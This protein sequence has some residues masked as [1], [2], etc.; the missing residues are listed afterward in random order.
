MMCACVLASLD[1]HGLY[2]C[3]CVAEYV[4]TMVV[5]LTGSVF[6]AV[7]VGNVLGF[8]AS[9]AS[10]NKVREERLN[11]VQALLLQF[12]VPKH[13]RQELRKWAV[14]RTRTVQTSLQ[15]TWTRTSERHAP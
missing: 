15:A 13:L 4:F 6:V 9:R 5:Q 11:G 12:S 14:R 3:V 10:Q 7:L 1:K 2:L 8:V